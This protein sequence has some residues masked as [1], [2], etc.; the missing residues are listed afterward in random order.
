VIFE[1]FDNTPSSRTSEAVERDAG[2]Y[3]AYIRAVGRRREAVKL[4]PDGSCSPPH[5]YTTGGTAIVLQNGRPGTSAGASN[6]GLTGS[7][8][9]ESGMQKQSH[10]KAPRATKKTFVHLR[11]FSW[12][13][14]PR[15][16]HVK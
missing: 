13:I 7:S 3:L 1:L 2:Q 8:S 12:P 6:R 14:S 10:K 15:L 9:A 11:A 4:E 16:A 5:A